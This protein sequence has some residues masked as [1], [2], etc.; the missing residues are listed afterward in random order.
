MILKYGADVN[1]KSLNGSTP[2]HWSCSSGDLEIVKLLVQ[3]GADVNATTN[4]W[5]TDSVYG[6]SSGQTPLHWASENN[7]IEVVLY[8]LQQGSIPSAQDERGSTPFDISDSNNIKN[9]LSDYNNTKYLCFQF[10]SS[11]IGYASEFSQL[12]SLWEKISN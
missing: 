11:S 6:K 2:L 9:L 8:L 5:L 10:D 1:I 7:K 12:L 3:Y 4:S